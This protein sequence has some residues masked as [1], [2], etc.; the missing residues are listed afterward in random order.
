M[1]LRHFTEITFDLPDRVKI[2]KFDSVQ[3]KRYFKSPSGFLKNPGI[4]YRL[5]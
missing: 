5:C 2:A 1:R 3:V 4:C